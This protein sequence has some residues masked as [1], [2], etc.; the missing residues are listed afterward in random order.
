M[1]NIVTKIKAFLLLS[2]D[3]NHFNRN[4]LERLENILFNFG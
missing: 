2:Y 1:T 3:L 4:N